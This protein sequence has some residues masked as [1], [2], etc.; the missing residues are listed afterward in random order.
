[1]S[2]EKPGVYLIE[3]VASGRVYVGS[4]A[5]I[6]KR[7]S[8]H[9]RDLDLGRHKNAHLL[10]AWRKY[11]PRA[12]RWTI[13]AIVE[14]AER[15]AVEQAVMDHLRATDP[16]RGFNRAAV[17]GVSYGGGS[18]TRSPEWRALMRQ[19]AA[20]WDR[21]YKIGDKCPADHV[22]DGSQVKRRKRPDGTWR[23]GLRCQECTRLDSLAR[24]RARAGIPLDWPRGQHY[25][26]RAVMPNG[27]A[28]S[29]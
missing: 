4:A 16:A 10:A 9:R 24:A 25:N 2:T 27:D 12:F 13:L 26:R 21:G 15:I 23:T 17:A 11:G 19:I 6:S 22:I 18:Q 28:R 20:G 7:W 1:M 14:P 29:E 5:N 8:R 3:H